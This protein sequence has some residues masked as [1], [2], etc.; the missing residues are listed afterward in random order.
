LEYNQA[1]GGWFMATLGGWV[2]KERLRRHW[3]QVDLE[4]KSGLAQSYISKIEGGSAGRVSL[5]VV[6]A[7]AKAFSI[8]LDKALEDSGW[9]EVTNIVSDLR[10]AGTPEVELDEMHR[11]WPL[12]PG[13][14]RAAMLASARAY[15]QAAQTESQGAHE[16][17]QA[18][19]NPGKRR[20]GT[21]HG[22]T[23]LRMPAQP[24]SEYRA[25]VQDAIEDAE[26]T[27]DRAS[28]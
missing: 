28:G 18:E 10:A 7:L 19:A 27:P 8:A 23:E 17:P 2:K 12:M 3:R 6:S 5:D 11:L 21:T 20:V 15:V 14:V 9:L 13:P 24:P 4:Q 26:D 25:R 16:V 22:D 1:R